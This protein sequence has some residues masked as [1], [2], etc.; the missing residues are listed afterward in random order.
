MLKLY[1]L[2]LFSAKLSTT[3]PPKSLKAVIIKNNKTETELSKLKKAVKNQVYGFKI[4]VK[5]RKYSGKV[6]QFNKLFKPE[7]LYILFNYK[8]RGWLNLYYRGKKSPKR[9]KLKPVL[10]R[11]V[12]GE[13]PEAIAIIIRFFLR[14]IANNPE[15]LQNSS[16]AVLEKSM[17]DRAENKNPP[18]LKK[19][20]KSKASRNIIKPL[21]PPSEILDISRSR[22]NL[23]RIFLKISGGNSVY[24]SQHLFEPY[25]GLE[26]GFEFVNNLYLGFSWLFINKVQSDGELVSLEIAR[27]PLEISGGYVFKYKCC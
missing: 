2:L 17:T 10:S 18:K 20:V 22:K 16:S 4:D 12:E 1:I 14:S 3:E 13:S 23:R 5:I 19:T 9:A 21:P 24:S 25:I 11:K 8:N 15:K 26:L 27:N 7:V 6:E